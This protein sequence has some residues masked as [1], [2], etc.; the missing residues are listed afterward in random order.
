M[1][2]DNSQVLEAY[3]RYVFNDYLASTVD[4]Q[5]MKD[6]MKEGSNTDGWIIGGRLTAEF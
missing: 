1:G 2:I 3:Y 5:Y 4:I 6:C